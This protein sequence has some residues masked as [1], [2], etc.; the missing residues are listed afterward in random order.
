MYIIYEYYYYVYIYDCIF[1]ASNPPI[2][3]QTRVRRHRTALRR[4][5]AAQ[6]KCPEKARMSNS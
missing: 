4:K 5:R 3:Y 6:N 1:H 2:P